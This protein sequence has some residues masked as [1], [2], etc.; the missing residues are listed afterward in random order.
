MTPAHASCGRAACVTHPPLCRSGAL[1]VLDGSSGQVAARTMQFAQLQDSGRRST[2]GLEV[3]GLT[4]CPTDSSVFALAGPCALVVCRAHWMKNA[5]VRALARLSFGAADGAGSG[6]SAAEPC[7]GSVAV[8]QVAF[9]RAH[10]GHLYCTDPLQPG[11]LMLLDF[12]AQA[13]I[14]TLVA[15]LAGGAHITALALNPQET[16]L[17][18]GTSSGTVLLLRLQ[19]EAWAELA[20]HAAGAPVAG[21]AFSPCGK[22]LFS[23]GTSATFVWTSVGE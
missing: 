1:Y 3:A 4:V 17:A 23:A 11:Q 2:S 6:H 13:V 9:S 22:Q 10:P 14:K 12:T 15:P 5:E 21:L 7:G 18:A 8:A 20:A 19:T 16:L